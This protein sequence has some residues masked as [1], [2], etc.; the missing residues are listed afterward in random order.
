M[1]LDYFLK[2]MHTMHNV[3]SV[4]RSKKALLMHLHLLYQ[5]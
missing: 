2:L 1:S 4:N 3:E 5:F